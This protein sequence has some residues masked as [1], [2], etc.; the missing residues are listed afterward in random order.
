MRLPCLASLLLTILGIAAGIGLINQPAHAKKMLRPRLFTFK[1]DDAM[2]LHELLPVPPTA[3]KL[4]PYLNENL[5][6]VPELTF[7]AP[8]GK[9]DDTEEKMAHI[10]AKINRMNQQTS[11]G[12]LKALV[13]DR[14]DL[15]GL[16]FLMGQDCRTEVVQAQLFSVMVNTIQGCQVL[17]K[18]DEK[19]RDEQLAADFWKTVE[20]IIS[21][22]EVKAVERL[23]ATKADVDRATIAALM[24]M[25]TPRSEPYRIGLARYLAKT[26]HGDATRAL[27]KLALFSPEE[28]VRSAAIDGLKAH[29]ANGNVLMQG[30]R[31]PL[32]A[33]AKR[34]AEAL[35]KLENKEVLPAL[36]KVLEEPDPRAPAKQRIDGQ[37]VTAVRELV[38][39]NHHRNCLLCHAPANTEGVPAHVLTTPVA[40]PDRSLPAPSEGYGDGSSPD[41]FIRTDMTYLRQDFSMMMKMDNAKPWPEMQRFDFFVRTRP[42]TPEEAA[43]CEKQLAKQTPPNHVAAL[44]ALTELT[45]LAPAEATAKGWRK[46]LKLPE[47]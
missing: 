7:G 14:P 33:V 22:I 23:K 16:P 25:I 8:F 2:P 31:Y 26:K 11:D 39:V 34:A 15:R 21:H 4:P 35:V 41:I 43:D 30:F 28:S 32:P 13:T 24:Q 20:A 6:L 9:V 18:T 46:E 17:D 10:V 44:F 12:F 37:E 47:R 5:A 3:P 19:T 36:V 27:A 45:G 38:R 40:L 29:R 1:I 42:V